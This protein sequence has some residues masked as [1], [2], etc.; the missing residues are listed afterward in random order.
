[1][2]ISRIYSS[3][4]LLPSQAVELGEK[5]SHYISRVLRLKE[6][7]GLILFDG[8]GRQ[9]EAVI[10]SI[11][12]KTVIVE[13]GPA[14]D[15]NLE[16]PLAIHLGIAISKGD[17]MDWVIQKATELGVSEITPLLSERVEVKLKGERLQKK[18]EHW[19]QISIS[20]CEQCG[21]NIVPTVHAL[22][23]VDNWIKTVS[24]EEKF[25]LH[26][27]AN[28]ILEPGTPISSL[29]LLIGPEGGLSEQEI[30]QAAQSG[31][32]QL[33]LGPRVLRTETAPLAAISILQ[34]I[35][36]DMN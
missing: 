12:K 9:F 1:M 21:R 33:T 6:G 17:R 7:A 22:S 35:W 26:H 10:N 2:R 5:A 19:Q 31:F 23:P 8:S 25:V 30:A 14:A 16:S 32:N 11:G 20:S 27:R 18:M 15:T 36:G 34:S 13:T 24:A 4:Q 29:A 28:C 3:V